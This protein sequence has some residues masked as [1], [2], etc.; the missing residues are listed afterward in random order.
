VSTNT[1]SP[2][3]YV[4]RDEHDVL[5][6]TGTPISLDSVVIAFRQGESPESI[7]QAYPSLTLEQ[8]YGSIA[9][10]LAHTDEVDAYLRRQEELWQRERAR[11]ERE[12]GPLLSRLRRLKSEAQPGAEPTRGGTE[13]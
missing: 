4:T 10:Y 8:V 12:N 7:R 3:R 9:Y 5:R 1:A 11:S 2:E 13:A 6:V